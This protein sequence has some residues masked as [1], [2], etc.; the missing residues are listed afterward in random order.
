MGKAFAD[1]GFTFVFVYV[2]EA[3]PGENYPAHTSMEQKIAQAQAFREHCNIE[4]P[5]L[6]DDLSASGHLL[7]GDLPNMSYHVGRGGIIL[8]RSAWT[9][10]PTIELMLSYRTHMR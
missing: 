9:T 5:I 8:F 6:A 3:H 4:R 10:P 2:R 7:Y 1:K